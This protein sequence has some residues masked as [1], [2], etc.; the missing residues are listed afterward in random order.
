MP[1]RQY[2]IRRGRVWHYNRAL[3]GDV[4][5]TR[6]EMFRR[7]L[8]TETLAE[9][10]R[11]RVEAERAY[12]AEVDGRRAKAGAAGTVLS[13][14][15]AFSVAAEWLRA[16]VAADEDA[17]SATLS[18]DGAVA[19]AEQEVADLRERIACLGHAGVRRAA[20]KEAEAVA[21]AQGF[22][23]DP[24]ELIRCRRAAARRGPRS[25]SRTG[26]GCCHPRWSTPTPP[27]VPSRQARA[28]LRRR[29]DGRWSCG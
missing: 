7:S 26:S 10:E 17:L 23:G 4:A 8:R 24:S 11:G 14:A 3:P 27:D 15:Q 16:R 28:R 21:R 2:L 25:P 22:D 20:L 18:I 9:A 12:F 6:G 1:S 19:D 29:D 5:R 13:R